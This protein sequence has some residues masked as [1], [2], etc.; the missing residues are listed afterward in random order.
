VLPAW[1]PPYGH[2][3][4][5]CRQQAWDAIREGNPAP[6]CRDAT[7]LPDDSTTQRWAWRKFV[8]F[9]T[10]IARPFL[11]AAADFFGAPTILAWDLAA[12]GRILR[13]EANSP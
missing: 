4:Y 1:S 3:S 5:N 7:R 9:W 12:A 13:L 6:L 2:Y 10:W 8:S 11:W